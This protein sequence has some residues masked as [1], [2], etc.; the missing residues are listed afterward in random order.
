[1][2]KALL[3]EI[4]KLGDPAYACYEQGFNEALAQVSH[5]A[6]GA[7]IDLSKVDQEKKLDEILAAEATSN[8]GVQT[9]GVGP[10]TSFEVDE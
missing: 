5:F 6:R 3:E 7:P 8:Q 2:E 9:M 4:K 1:M 10:R